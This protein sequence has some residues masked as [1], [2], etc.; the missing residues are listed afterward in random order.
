MTT[1]ADQNKIEE[2]L[3]RW[4]DKIYPSKEGFL[5]AL[6]G[7]KLVIYH[8]VDPTAPKLHLGHSTN[9]LLLRE[10]QKLGHKIILLIGDFTAR[11][12]DP[13]GRAEARKALTEKEVRK[14]YKDYKKQ[15]GKILDFSSRNNPVQIRF[16]SKWF[17]KMKMSDI[18]ELT[19]KYTQGKMIKRNMFQERLKNNQEIYLSEFLYPLFQG[20]DSVA[21][22]VDVE[23][24]GKDQTFNMLVGRDLL[25]AYK[26]KEKFVVTT[27]LLENPKTGKKLMSKSEGNFIA[28]DEEPNQM[29][30]KVMAL[31][32]E[33][34][35]PCFN[36]CTAISSKDIKE[37]E[38]DLRFNKINPKDVKARLAGEIVGFYHNK[39][40]AENAEK[41][42]NRVFREREM[43][44]D[45]PAI[46]IPEGKIPILDL[47]V[48]AKTV[49]SKSEAKRL[50]M[51]KG[52][53]IDNKVEGDWRK[54]IDVKK[55]M[56][57]QAG[58]RKFV[59]IA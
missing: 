51:Q 32:D 37:I 53:K 13:T 12:G 39:K 31:P 28:L 49:L 36:L 56:T 48:N 30:G 10:F 15:A 1:G 20:Y 6:S 42:F 22:N 40:A 14:N 29:Y 19:A 46:K 58:R 27:L 24:G 11:I 57:I 26:G 8:G 44:T 52:V 34:I 17:S 3:E 55:G 4:V 33:A 38:D 35:I 47:L 41:E 43:P 54:I 18:M 5:A 16:N 21:M 7:K 59:K 45:I 9:Y 23:V 50:I 25:K 2:F